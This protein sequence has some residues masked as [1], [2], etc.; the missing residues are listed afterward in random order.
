MAEGIQHQSQFR[1]VFRPLHEA[2]RLR[3]VKVHHH[4]DQQS[5]P[6]DAVALQ[7][8]LQPLIDKAL[9]GGVLVH[10]DEAVAGLGEDIG[11]VQLRPGGTERAIHVHGG[12]RRLTGPRI[13]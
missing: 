2:V 12:G 8:G 1:E 4:R 6:G 7:R 13:G 5:L 11:L 3:W 10:E 9:M